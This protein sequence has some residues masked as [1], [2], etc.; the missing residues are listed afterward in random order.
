MCF[1]AAAA[2]LLQTVLCMEGAF[3]TNQNQVFS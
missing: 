1:G 3:G 2:V